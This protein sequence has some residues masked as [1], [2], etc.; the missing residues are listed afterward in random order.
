MFD[1]LLQ[2]IKPESKLLVAGEHLAQP[3]KGAHHIH[4]QLDCPWTV[5][6]GRRHDC[7]MFGK[8]ERQITPSPATGGFLV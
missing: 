7:P 6:D 1:A 2:L 8:N 5:Q 4:R 3:H